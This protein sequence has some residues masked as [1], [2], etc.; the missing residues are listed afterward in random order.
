MIVQTMILIL[1]GLTVLL[2][3]LKNHKIRRWGY[4]AGLASEPFWL[5]WAWGN[6]G[7]AVILLIIWYSGCYSL[8]IWNNFRNLRP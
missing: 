1:G 6:D 8:G 3:A 7:W 5:I 2:L 4:V